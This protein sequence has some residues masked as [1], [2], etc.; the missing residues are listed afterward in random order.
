MK[1]YDIDEIKKNLETLEELVVELRGE[2][3]KG[4]SPAHYARLA[5]I[6]PQLINHFVKGRTKL[7]RDSLFRLYYGVMKEKSEKNS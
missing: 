1:N 2:V 4:G 6:S 3:K 5:N 7:E